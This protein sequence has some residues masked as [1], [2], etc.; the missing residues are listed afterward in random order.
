MKKKGLILIFTGHGKGKTTAAL[1]MSIRA[2]G[3]GMKT[4]FIQF[5]KGSWKYGEMEALTRF[6]EEIDFYVTGRGFTWKSDDL[7]KDKEAAREAGELT[8]ALTEKLDQES[9]QTIKET[10][11]TYV[12]PDREAFRKVLADVHKPLEGKYWPTGMVDK[13]RAMQN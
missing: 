6:R 2:A 1:G 7:E 8:T 9:I 3:H 12:V 10:G 5:I 13:I 4:C 11:G